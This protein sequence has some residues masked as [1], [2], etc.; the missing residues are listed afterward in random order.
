MLEFKDQM[1]EPKT[2]GPHSLEGL[3]GKTVRVEELSLHS[4][5]IDKAYLR[6]TDQGEID[7][8]I[9]L[10]HEPV[11]AFKDRKVSEYEFRQVCS[12]QLSKESEIFVDTDLVQVLNKSSGEYLKIDLRQTI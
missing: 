6:I 8:I 9:N 2:Q 4:D 7:L 12:L 11:P 10:E 3:R 5:L 1:L